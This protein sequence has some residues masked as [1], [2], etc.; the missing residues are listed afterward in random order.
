MTQKDP[1]YA[2]TTLASKTVYQNKW[3]SVREDT[4][5]RPSGQQGIYSVVEKPHFAV[6]IPCDEGGVVMVEQYRYPVRRRQLE[7]PQGTAADDPN[8]DP[9]TL[10]AQ[11][12]KEETGYTAEHWHYVGFQYMAH[13]LSTQGYHIYLAKGLQPGAQQLDAEEEDLTVHHLSLTELE[14]RI[15]AG[16]I[17]DATTCNALGLA[18]LKGLL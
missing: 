15:V 7:F 2:F 6:I 18:R 16:E 8:I 17:T 3:V 10:A 12:L 1:K 4:I 14:R 5:A 9:A 13:G 11:E